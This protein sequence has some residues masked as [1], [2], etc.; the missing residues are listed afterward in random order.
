MLN[1]SNI[2]E[3]IDNFIKYKETCFKNAVLLQ[4]RMM[5]V[6]EELRF[7][8]QSEEM[9]NNDYEEDEDEEFDDEFDD[10]ESPANSELFVLMEVYKTIM[11]GLEDE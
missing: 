9:N 8:K 7:D 6:L 11:K 1:K 10:E 5:E 2:K 3:D 4:N